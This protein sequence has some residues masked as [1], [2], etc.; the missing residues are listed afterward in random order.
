MALTE[1][2]APQIEE[3]RAALKQM[4][5]QAS[6]RFGPYGGG[7]LQRAQARGV[8]QV[9]GSLAGLAG[10]LPERA[11]M[12]LSSLIENF[13]TVPQPATP[14]M[15]IGTQPFNPASV[16]ASLKQG[17]EMGKVANR[18]DQWWNARPSSLGGAYPGS[19]TYDQQSIPYD[20]GLT[21]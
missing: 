16:W 8:Q 7:Q 2:M 17:A 14:V 20:Y 3:A 15:Q 1:Q 19:L 6:Q 18:V 21:Y 11:R 12:A 13:Q 4:F 5:Q 10:Q 9:G